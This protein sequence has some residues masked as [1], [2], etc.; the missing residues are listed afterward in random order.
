MQLISPLQL[1][2]QSLILDIEPA[3]G[4]VE[5]LEVNNCLRGYSLLY[6]LP[7]IPT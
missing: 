4:C 7:E 5:K 6:S 2:Y 3:P 1:Q